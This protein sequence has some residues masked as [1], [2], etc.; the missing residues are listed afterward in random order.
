MPWIWF[1]V[2]IVSLALAGVVV[3]AL[4]AAEVTGPDPQRYTLRVWQ[5]GQVIMEAT[6]AVGIQWHGSRT[7]TFFQ[8]GQSRRWYLGGAVFQQ[9]EEVQ[10]VN[11]QN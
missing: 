9:L 8:R 5:G 11:E 1:A 10:N 4:P 3:S 6:G 2:V 7:V